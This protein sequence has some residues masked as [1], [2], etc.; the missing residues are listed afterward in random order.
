L[1]GAFSEFG[2]VRVEWPGKEARYA[3]S[4][5]KP[6]ARSKGKL[7]QFLVNFILDWLK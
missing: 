6:I 3:K 7:F 2:T 4:P 1:I 5:M